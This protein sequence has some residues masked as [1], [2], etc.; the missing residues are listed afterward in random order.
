L[1]EYSVHAEG[2]RQ[3]KKKISKKSRTQLSWNEIIYKGTLNNCFRKNCIQ[4]DIVSQE[5]QATPSESHHV[6]WF[7]G[8]EFSP[9]NLLHAT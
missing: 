7:I 8:G 3:D 5:K 1:K 4:V 2:F 9:M 6:F